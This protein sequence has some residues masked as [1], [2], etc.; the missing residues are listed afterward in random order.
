MSCW[1]EFLTVVVWSIDFWHTS[2]WFLTYRDNFWSV[3]HGATT[4]TW[5]VWWWWFSWWW[6]SWWRLN[7]YNFRLDL[8]FVD[9]YCCLSNAVSKMIMRLWKVKKLT[10]TASVQRW[11]RGDLIFELTANWHRTSFAAWL[12][13]SQNLSPPTTG[14][15]EKPRS[16]YLKMW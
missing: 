6:H 8:D 11:I 1:K 9:V 10:L 5:W 4:A 12:L 2:F 16:F 14:N 3:W 15:Q 13:A 7:C